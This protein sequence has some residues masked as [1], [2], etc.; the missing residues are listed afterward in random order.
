MKA[1]FT[2]FHAKDY[3]AS[4]VFYEDVIGLSVDRDFAST[5]HRFTNYNLGGMVLKVYEWTEEYFG[6]GHSGLFIATD[7]LDE[8]IERVVSAG[9]KTSGIEVHEWGGRTCSVWDP[10]GNIFS[11]IDEKQAGEI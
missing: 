4:K 7:A 5:P 11:L 3:A 8:V 9:F 1:L 10:S 2:S 6:S